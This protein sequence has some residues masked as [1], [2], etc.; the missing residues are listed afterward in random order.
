MSEAFKFTSVI[1]DR[2]GMFQDRVC[3][4]AA[5]YQRG[6]LVWESITNIMLQFSSGSTI[7]MYILETVL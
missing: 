6:F 2:D 1:G 7:G 4:A 5:E 3:A